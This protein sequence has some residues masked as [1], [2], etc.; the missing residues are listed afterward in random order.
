[1]V[2]PERLYVPVELIL[3]NKNSLYDTLESGQIGIFE[4]PTGTVIL[5]ILDQKLMPREN[6]SQLSVVHSNGYAIIKRNHLK[7]K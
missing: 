5:G 3:F 2:Y 7:R 6:L 1:M 4:S